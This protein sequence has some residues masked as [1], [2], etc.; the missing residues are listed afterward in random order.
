VLAAVQHHGYALRYASAE[1][2]A[3]RKVV[4]AAVQQDGRVLEYASLQS[5]PEGRPRGH[6]GCGA[7]EWVHSNALSV[8]QVLHLLT[9]VIHPLLIR[10]RYRWFV[11]FLF[12]F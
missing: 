12:H 4:L 5:C 11:I 2:Q 7:A 8:H 3:D 1:L 9:I 6:A 10:R